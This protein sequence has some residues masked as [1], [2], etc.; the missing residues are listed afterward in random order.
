MSLG[1]GTQLL[2]NIFKLMRHKVKGE[3]IYL[4]FG[5]SYHSKKDTNY[6]G[7]FSE[8]FHAAEYVTFKLGDYDISSSSLFRITLEL[9]VKI[10]N[11]FF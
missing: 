2:D 7:K 11:S 5:T 6:A 3:I 9:V 4:H 10:I 1:V 8:E